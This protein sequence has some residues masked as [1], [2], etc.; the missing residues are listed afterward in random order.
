MSWQRQSTGR[1]IEG[2]RDEVLQGI[3]AVASQQP[4]HIAVKDLD[5]SL[6]YGELVDECARV[7]ASLV[8]RGVSRGDRVVILI[9]NSVDYVVAALSCLWIG[10]IFVPLDVYDVPR[11]ISSFLKDCQPSVVLMRDDEQRLLEEALGED[12]R[13]H[14]LREF[15]ASGGA[16]RYPLVSGERPAYIIYTSGTTGTPKGVTIGIG[17][18]S[19]AVES[20]SAT[21]SMDSATRTLCV[22]PFHFDGSFAT[23]FP[24]LVCGGTVVLRTPQALLFPRVF[25]NAVIGESITNTGVTPS[26]L[27][28]LI[29]SPQLA[30]LR[31]STL[32][33]LGLGGEAISA[34]D[35]RRLWEVAPHIRIFNR[36]GPTETTIAVTQFEITPSMAERDEVPIGVPH[37][38]VDF[39]LL[40]DDKRRV[41]I[42]NQRAE[43]YIGG[44]QLMDGYWNAPELTA[45]VMSENFLPGQLLYRTRDIAFFDEDGRYFFVE[46]SD[47]I[48]KRGGSRISMAEITQAFR[49]HSEVSH[50]LTLTFDNEGVVGIVTFVMLHRP[51]SKV[52][53]QR[54]VRGR[55]PSWSLPDRIEIVDSLPRTRSGKTDENA[56]RQ[57]RG[58]APLSKTST[59]RAFT[60]VE[61]P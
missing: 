50:A 44:R 56:L 7:S 31:N 53:L 47:R 55:L 23:L 5:R 57:S 10:A 21:F 15:A 60:D 29:T 39:V 6:T 40:D 19:A 41:T 11:R 25:F 42:P 52:D 27:R 54:W 28:T 3:M 9:P 14:L 22:K 58:L 4:R 51:L 24:T 32:A 33:T 35:L 16:S 49:S 26:Y 36:Y 43:L 2:E 34:A 45:E 30:Q 8:E 48:V 1:P 46:R 37:P 12:S 17:A 18:F 13:R 59:P 20:G 61:S 38:G